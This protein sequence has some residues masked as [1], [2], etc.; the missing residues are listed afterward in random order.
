MPLLQEL[1]RFLPPLLRLGC[2]ASYM[3]RLLAFFYKPY[4]VQAFLISSFDFNKGHV[5][6]VDLVPRQ[7]LGTVSASENEGVGFWPF[8]LLPPMS[9]LFSLH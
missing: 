1:D 7:S 3:A 6:V 9:I 4:V 5:C 2:S 8:T